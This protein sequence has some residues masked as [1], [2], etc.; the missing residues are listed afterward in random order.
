MTDRQEQEKN[1]TQ[2]LRTI[3][4]AIQAHSKEIEKACG[5][6][7]VR[8]WMLFAIKSSPGIK[9]SE[10][11][12]V[13]SIHRSTSSNLLDKLENMDLIYRQRSKSDQ[14][15]VHLFITEKGLAVLKKSPSPPEGKLKS[16][17]NK[18][19]PDKLENLEQGLSDLIEVLHFKD[20]KAALTPIEIS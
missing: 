16:S 3:F 1:I 6:S 14:R 17:L 5:L 13:L 15:S 4:K 10:L 9:V 12:T 7:S 19:P 18:L 2:Q 8:L 20:D 11:A